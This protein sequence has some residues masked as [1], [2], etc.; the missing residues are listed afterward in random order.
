MGS[1]VV[2]KLR[3]K[4]KIVP[5][6]HRSLSLAG[7][8]QQFVLPDNWDKISRKELADKIRTNFS[9]SNSSKNF[10]EL[11]AKLENKKVSH[12]PK[13]AKSVVLP[14]DWENFK[15]TDHLVEMLKAANPNK[16][17]S[18]RLLDNLAR[19]RVNSTEKPKPKKKDKDRHRER[20]RHKR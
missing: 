7:Q 1:A 12:V 18:G 20:K 14:Q 16:E 5:K 3:R 9:K 4:Q 17:I 8:N 10:T 6:G 19:V 15:G 11:F 13:N 2:D